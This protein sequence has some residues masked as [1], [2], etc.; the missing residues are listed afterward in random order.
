MSKSSKP[1]RTP[2]QITRRQALAAC[3]V[4]AASF[5]PG[6]S[7]LQGLVNGI[8]GNA[9]ADTP[10]TAAP[11][12]ATINY[13]LQGGPLRTSWDLP[14]SPYANATPV[15]T[16]L[17][18]TK[19]ENGKAVYRT[20][21]VNLGSK[22]IYMPW[23]WSTSIP[24]VGGGSVAMSELMRNMLMVR[25]IEG[26]TPNHPDAAK[27]KTRPI[28]SAPSIMGVIAD[29]SSAPVQ[30]VIAGDYYGVP[31]TA[32]AANHSAQVH[33]TDQNGPIAQLL[34]P[35]NRAND[36]VNSDFLSRRAALDSLIQNG[37][38]LLAT[39]ANSNQPGSDALFGMRGRAELLMRNGVQTAIDAYPALRKKYQDLIRACAN[40]DQAGITDAAI[41][42][43][44]GNSYG[45]N[46]T[47]VNVAGG[48]F[49]QNSD[50]RT[51]IT[52]SSKPYWMAENFAI[53]EILVTQGLSSSLMIGS[54]AVF[55]LQY[56]SLE[57]FGSRASTTSS[58]WD[59]DEHFGGSLTSLLA[60][61][62]L[63]RCLSA[64][65]YELQSSL[66]SKNS[67]A[68]GT[69]WDQTVFFVSGDFGR[70]PRVDIGDQ[71][72]NPGGADHDPSA[73]N[74]SIFSGAIPEPLVLG[75]VGITPKTDPKYYGHW[76]EAR[77]V[78]QVGRNL[79]CA[80]VIS[81]IAQLANVASP[82]DNFGSLLNAAGAPVVEL[83]KE[84]A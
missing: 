81:T 11:I 13:H 72:G 33:V 76:G 73:T 4:G 12:K 56:D 17:S 77:T 14:L 1:K 82:T 18:G 19:I 32:F 71:A 9:N 50:V 28:G 57:I 64:C 42:L 16:P 30:A 52:S 65:L 8:I 62:F 68:G 44:A 63:Y 37:L 51:I 6:I 46:E 5:H 24:T 3:G 38:S 2:I 74:Y 67:A 29:A 59:F 23:V 27:E 53:A 15:L 36:G 10:A 21:P 49:A 34:G 43:P 84:K 55:G 45:I 80:D 70:N 66:K 22:T 48:S 25:G 78:A 69:L 7:L 58:S 39:A 47:V 61:A 79:D 41:P 83:A 20:T 26:K 35:F 75:N 40:H 60:N 31:T 54:E